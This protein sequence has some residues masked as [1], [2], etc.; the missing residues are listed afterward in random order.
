MVVL[1]MEVLGVQSVAVVA[2]VQEHLEVTRLGL[3]GAQQELE[4]HR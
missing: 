4:E 3:Q 2:V 1:A